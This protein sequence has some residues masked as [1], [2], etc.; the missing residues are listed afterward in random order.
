MDKERWLNRGAAALAGVYPISAVRDRLATEAWF[1]ANNLRPAARL[2]EM[3][4]QRIQNDRDPELN[5]NVRRQPTRAIGRPSMGE[6]V[7]I[8]D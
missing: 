3:E 4:K 1:R 8:P 5:P 6:I 7:G 2:A